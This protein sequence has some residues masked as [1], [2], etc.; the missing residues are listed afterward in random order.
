MRGG[1]T[2]HTSAPRI[3]PRTAGYAAVHPGYGELRL[4]DGWVQAKLPSTV[5]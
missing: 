2:A 5:Q 1:R 3:S 4:K